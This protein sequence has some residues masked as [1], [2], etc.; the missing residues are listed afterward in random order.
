M[1]FLDKLSQIV[2][3]KNKSQKKRE[4]NWTVSLHDKAENARQP[5]AK[6]HIRTS[7]CD[8]RG[9]R[10]GLVRARMCLLFCFRFGGCVWVCVC[11]SL[12]V[13][14]RSALEMFETTRH[15]ITDRYTLLSFIPK[16]LYE[17]FRRIANLYAFRKKHSCAALRLCRISFVVALFRTSYFLTVS[18]IQISCSGCSPTNKCA[19]HVSF[20]CGRQHAFM[21]RRI[22]LS[23]SFLFGI[24]DSRRLDRWSSCWPWL[25]SRR[26]T[27][28]EGC[29]SVISVV[30]LTTLTHR[31][32]AALS[33]LGCLAVE[34]CTNCQWLVDARSVFKRHRQDKRQ[35]STTVEC[36][37]NGVWISREWHLLRVRPSRP[38]QQYGFSSHWPFGR[39]T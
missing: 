11:V 17:Q 36:L 13:G 26:R 39:L 27:K 37:I 33:A 5:H 10:R 28:T 24:L 23:L 12:C 1:S 30:W 32:V 22:L 38:P 34:R 9:R 8:A 14:A 6:N 2:P 16:N 15:T 4:G 29:P 35:N 25:R 19:L 21:R 3:G 7:R 31:D 20:A 18:V